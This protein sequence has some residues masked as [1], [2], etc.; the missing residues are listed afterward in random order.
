MKELLP[1]LGMLIER[2]IPTMTDLPGPMKSGHPTSR[3]KPS[4]VRRERKAIKAS[5]RRS[6]R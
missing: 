1:L 2:G 5:R 6:R 4:H 3:R